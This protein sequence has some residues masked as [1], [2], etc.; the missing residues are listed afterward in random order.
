MPKF[1]RKKILLAK[2]EEVYGADSVPTGALNAILATDVSLT[3]MEGQDLSRA[4]DQPWFGAQPTVPV[5]LHAKLSFKVELAG[6]GAAGTAP[7]W[8][9]ILRA[10]GLAQTISAG[11]SVTYN[12]I[13]DNP[14]SATLYLNVDGTLMRLLGARGTMTARVAAS[15]IPY[16]E[17]EMTGLYTAPTDAAAPVPDY[18]A[19][20]KPLHGSAAN[21]PVFTLGGTSLVMRSFM[22]NLGNAVEGRFLIGA[23]N[24]L[25]TDRTS[26]IE[27]TVEA[28]ALATFDPFSRAAA[29]TDQAIVLTHGTAAGNIVTLN[30]PKAQMQRPAGLEQ[31]QNIVEWPLRLV[32]IPSAGN[33]EFTLTLT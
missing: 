23:E 17:F 22:L 1:W 13:T 10:C 27:A 24:I 29:Q 21:T 33:D 15:G 5:D 4:L 18:A 2:I 9:P 3:P 7:A 31:N 20:Q 30:V 28:V 8:G 11:V 16:L 19:F 25:I 14:E 26:T 12:P 6:S 32:P